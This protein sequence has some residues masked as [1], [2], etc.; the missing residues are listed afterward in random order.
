MLTRSDMKSI[1]TGLFVV[2]ALSSCTPAPKIPAPKTI[3]GTVQIAGTGTQSNKSQV[4]PEFVPGE[5]LVTFKTDLS[6]RSLSSL[7]AGGISMRA[8]RASSL[9]RTSLYRS[10]AARSRAQT[11][12]LV[13]SLKSRSD[14]AWA[15]PNQI[16]RATVVPG[17]PNDPEFVKQWHYNAINLPQAWDVE[18]GSNLGPNPNSSAVTVAVVDTGLLLNHPDIQGKFLPGY[19]FISSSQQSN[20]GNGRDNNPDDPGDIVGGQSSYHGSHV[21]GTIAAKTDN[22]TGVAGVSWGAKILPVRVLGVDGGSTSDIIDGILWAAGVPVAGVGTNPNPAQ[23]INLSLGGAGL[24]EAASVLQ[25]TFDQVNAK[26]A[27]V[28]V[29]AGNENVE[30]ADT[31]PAS[32]SGVITVGATNKAGN[33]AALYSNYGPRIDVMAPGGE[34]AGGNPADEVFSLGKNDSNK[35]FVYSYKQ[36]TSMATPHVAGVI[37]L[38]KSKD[39]T[40]NFS[41]VLSILKR[42]ARPLTATQCSGTGSGSK[43]LFPSDCGAGL[44]NAE[45]A[46]GELNTNPDFSLTLT[47]SSVIAE[48]GQT[49][50]VQVSQSNVGAVAAANLQ[51]IDPDTKASLGTTTTLGSISGST[52]TVKV[53]SNQPFGTYALRIQGSAG[54]LLRDASLSL[55]VIDLNAQ[56]S[57]QED[58]NG[59]FMFFCYYVNQRCDSTKSDGR[60]IE[61]SGTSSPYA[62]AELQDGDYV[63][64]AWKDVDGS[65]KINKG[66]LLGAYFVGS[67]LGVLRPPASAIMVDLE[68]VQS[69]NQPNDSKWGRA[70]DLFS[71]WQQ[72]K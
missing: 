32:C 64:I 39:P 36:G 50:Q 22:G 12:A 61:K 44:I 17:V 14:V 66:D 42:T 9:E 2:L 49:V 54:G 70:Q 20:D 18:T 47:P 29:A 28:V 40:L 25:R 67:D 62:S 19:D 5:V 27:I 31:I 10:D 38:L 57:G 41:R 45:A 11:L 69:V 3:S 55:N 53:P 23:V 48:R 52:L 16:L 13:E 24:C 33:R 30:A 1:W 65:K 4:A 35:Q 7:S 37:A 26:G 59:T 58:V 6:A 63:V 56:P 21:A 8:V 60:F 46:L 72:S 34:N 51:F 15:E 71:T 68:I 43:A